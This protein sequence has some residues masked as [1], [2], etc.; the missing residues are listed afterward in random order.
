MKRRRTFGNLFDRRVKIGL[1]ATI[2]IGVVLM[3]ILA[4]LLAPHDPFKQNLLLRLQP[5]VWS[6]PGTWTYPLGTDNYG[7]D[8]LSRL[9]YGSRLSIMV[10]VSA[11]L[12]SAV[13][14]TV[15]GMLAGFKG[16]RLEQVIMRFADAHLAFPEVLL[17]ILIIASIGGS[18][19]NLIL[20]LGISGWM[21]YARV[22]Y[23]MTR[24]LRERPFIEAAVSH[25]AGD[26]YIIGRHI[27]PQL[28][29]VLTVV[30]TLQ[31]AQMILQETA[32][33]F[34]GLGLPPPTATWGNMLAEGRDRL[35]A[36]PWIANLSG[37]A[38][39]I[40]VWGIN[41]LGNGLREQLDPKSRQRR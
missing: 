37:L 14:G 33:S 8:M 23:N 22:M 29:P 5:P 26:L 28:V 10:G 31:V 30:G 19:V 2:V 39:I 27:F 15:L 40:V 34:L 3:A 18:A 1:G 25:G 38:I 4:P 35:W 12:L 41:M 6:E 13:L 20:V 24:S 16:G 7:R 9:I 17:A 36:A 32:L 21:V 11:A